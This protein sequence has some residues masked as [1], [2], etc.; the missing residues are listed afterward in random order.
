MRT[1]ELVTCPRD[2]VDRLGPA[3]VRGVVVRWLRLVA[4]DAE[5]AP[6]LIGIDR[7]HLVDRLTEQLGAALG[8]PVTTRR[9]CVGHWRCLGLS[10]EQ[11]L[12]VLDY[13]AASLYRH[14]VPF[15]VI[16]VAQRIAAGRG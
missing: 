8:G 13:L 3:G 12:R 15:D 5:L 1:K 6:Y 16:T 7:P 2:P 4:A 10:E 9:T 11:H 14:D